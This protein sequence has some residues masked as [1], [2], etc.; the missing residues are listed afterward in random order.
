MS[1]A[2]SDAARPAPKRSTNHPER[3]ASVEREPR[4]AADI[5]VLQRAVG[6][7]AVQRLLEGRRGVGS[8]ASSTP[9]VQRAPGRVD[10]FDDDFDEAD[11]IDDDAEYLYDP[12]RNPHTLGRYLLPALAAAE[13]KATPGAEEKARRPAEGQTRLEEAARA[14][15]AAEAQARAEAEAKTKEAAEAKAR[16]AAEAKARLEEEARQAAEAKAK[17]EAEE[18]ARQAAEAQARLEEEARRAAEAEAQARKEAVA[19]AKEEAAAKAKAEAEAKAAQEELA[20][21]AEIREELRKKL[22]DNVRGTIVDQWAKLTDVQRERFVEQVFNQKATQTAYQTAKTAAAELAKA[23]ISAEREAAL[24]ADKVW[25][26]RAVDAMTAPAEIKE[27][28][29]AAIALHRK[30]DDS[31]GLTVEKAYPVATILEACQLWGRLQK[32]RVTD[33]GA[34]VPIRA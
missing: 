18:R 8:A 13:A 5:L 11:E 28:F 23:V 7:H 3:G 30:S 32:T 27:M 20:K 26:N 25:L 34:A 31:Y 19:K 9:V 16:E 1:R 21:K 24:Q 6:N 17:Q 22:L 4:D 12:A 2:R 33:P 10:G 15:E 14:K 29:M